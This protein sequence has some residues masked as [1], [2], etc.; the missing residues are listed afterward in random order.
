MRTLLRIDSS[1][2]GHGSHSRALGDDIERLWR[3]QNPAGTVVTRDLAREPV[4]LIDQTTIEGFF[5]P[6]AQLTR[7]QK[8]ATALSDHLIAELQRADELLVTVPLYNFGVPAGLKAWIDQVVRV[9]HTF[10]Y[11][12]GRFSGLANTSCAYVACAYGAG[13]YLAGGPL[14]RGDFMQPY[15]E[16]VLRFIGI[17]TVHVIA[18]EA[19]NG[20]P[21]SRA[22]SADEARRSAEALFQANQ[23]DRANA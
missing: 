9:G 19:T 23:G 5:T 17:D 4:A 10:N 22:L 6:Q 15:L 21:Q 7:A 12:S 20:D 1:A 16:F 18:V 3:N 11:E 14:A 2:R 8:E 13:G